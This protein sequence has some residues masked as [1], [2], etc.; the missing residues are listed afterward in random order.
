MPLSEEFSRWRDDPVTK[1][2][3]R[4]LDAAVD[5][6]KVQW[7]TAS[8]QGGLVRA[9]DLK[10]LLQEL[11]VRADCYAALRDMTFEDIAAWLGIETNA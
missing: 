4:A 8:W 3:L 2:V 6:Q 1:L 10:D 7:D 11:R 5:A 9:D